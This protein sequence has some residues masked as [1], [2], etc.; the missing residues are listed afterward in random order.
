MA[1][2]DSAKPQL[3]VLYNLRPAQMEQLEQS[4]TLHRLNQADDKASLLAAVGP[5]IRGVVTSGGLGFKAEMLSSLPLL[6]IVASSG[7]GTDS[8]DIAAC[9]AR[10]IAVTNTPDVLND[11]VADLGIGLIMNALRRLGD[12]HAYTR[13]GD[14]GRLGMMTLTTSLKGKR[15]GIVGL[16]RI[17]HELADRASALKMQIAYTGRNK[18][19]VGYTYYASLAELASNSDVL[20]LTCPGGKQTYHIIDAAVLEALGP[21]GWLVNLA[22]GSVVDEAAL[23]DALE[24]RRIAGAAL[25]VFENEPNID[26]RFSTLDNVVLYPHHASGT[27]ETRD[28]MSQLV[29]DNLIAHF[30]QRPLVTPV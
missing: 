16:G 22:R 10:G 17:G 23:I 20:A 2:P 8:I 13:S 29:V 21:K 26:P 30:Q 3:L 6:E 9:H 11:D 18:Q 4:F 15:L 14:W 5:N 24:Q 19:D 25:D 12:G 27:T 28:A 1:H 7:V